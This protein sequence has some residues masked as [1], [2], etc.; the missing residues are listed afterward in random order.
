MNGIALFNA[1]TKIDDRFIDRAE[2]APDQAERLDVKR[3][4]RPSAPRRSARR[5]VIV[6]ECACL[7]LCVSLLIVNRIGPFGPAGHTK[8]KP[9]GGSAAWID[10]PVAAATEARPSTGAW[11][12]AGVHGGTLAEVD[13]NTGYNIS[14]VG[15][16]NYLNFDGGNQAIYPITGSVTFNTVDEMVAAI[17]SN[18]LS[19]VQCEIIRNSFPQNGNG[20]LVIDLDHVYNATLPDELTVGGVDWEGPSYTFEFYDENGVFGNLRVL[21]K[22]DYET[23]YADQ[24]TAFF[25][26]AGITVLSRENVAERNAEVILY[27]TADGTY[28]AIRYALSNGATVV[29]TYSAPG[30]TPLA[31]PDTVELYRETGSAAFYAELYEL[32]ERPTVEWLSKFGLQER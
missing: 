7:L 26:R 27:E 12:E 10:E 17:R 5:W 19:A 9:V 3:T 20:F 25:D 1:L 23:L 6:A 28:R 13:E 21:T 14:V 31:S 15:G 8:R 24:Y 32:T 18:S 16:R 4:E 2:K 29:E 30:G 22:E 11:S